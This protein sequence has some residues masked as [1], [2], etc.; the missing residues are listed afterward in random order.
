MAKD[1]WKGFGEAIR[2]ATKKAAGNTGA[3]VDAAKVRARING[4]H[5]EID[6]L[7]Q[8]LG[9]SVF[10]RAG[11]DFSSF[12]DED[13]AAAEEIIAHRKEISDLQSELAALKGMKVCPGCG[14]LIDLSA[15][16][17]PKCGA[18]TPV[19]P[20]EVRPEDYMEEPLEDAEE[21]AESPDGTEEVLDAE[22]QP[23]GREA[24]EPEDGGAMNA[25]FVVVS[26]EAEAK[27]ETEAE[28]EAEAE[29]QA[30]PEAE[31]ETEEVPAGSEPEPENP[32]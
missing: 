27:P 13:R 11:G 6:K 15:V 10:R 7:F 14:E 18:K 12:S 30:E 21:K 16:F 31:P 1:I 28:P 3:L 24:E 17:C 32:S 29:A 26:E 8:R 9:E 5:K 4:E 23:L 20:R 19:G 25:E 22:F 2:E